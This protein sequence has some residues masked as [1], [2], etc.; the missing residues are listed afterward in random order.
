MSWSL[1]EVEVLAKKAAK[2]AGYS[3]GQAEDTGRAVRWLE[4]RGLKG[5]AALVA[6]LAKND[7]ALCPITTG[8]AVADGVTPVGDVDLASLDQPMLFLPFAFWAGEDLSTTL[9][10]S[11]DAETCRSF[12][13]AATM[14][15]LAAHAHK[16][17][18]PATDESR[19]LG[20]GAGL[21]DN[22]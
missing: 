5:A 15:A 21:T 8:I 11:P 2:G 4:A 6:H 9:G 17:Y 18:A 12:T 1:N 3:W 20:A 16:T 13:D 14:A 19:A 10:L 22:D 7:T